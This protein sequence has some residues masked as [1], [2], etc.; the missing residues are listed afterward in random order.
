MKTLLILSL[1]LALASCSL[2]KLTREGENVAVLN[3][4][5]VANC[6]R[7]GDTTVSVL[8]KV[9]I[10]RDQTKVARELSI[11]ARNAGAGRGGDTVVAT[12]VPSN[13]QQSFDIYQCRR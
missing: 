4:D 3:L 2:V 9:G 8:A 11:L 5:Q 1:G 10:T 6:S 13:G 12:S 7:V